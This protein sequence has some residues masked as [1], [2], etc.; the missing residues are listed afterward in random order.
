MAQASNYFILVAVDAET[1]EGKRVPAHALLDYRL[2]LKSWPLFQKTRNRF[3]MQPGDRLLFY[4]GGRQLNSRC[5]VARATIKSIQPVSG[6]PTPE[7]MLFIVD[8]PAQMVELQ[9]V[10]MFER[11]LDFRSILPLLDCAPANQT[12][13]GV[14]L[15]GGVRRISGKDYSA[16][17][18]YGE[19]LRG[20]RVFS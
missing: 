18:K 11:A 10:T 3:L 19:E 12:K 9:D 20:A 1:P 17:I 5:L 16:I 13:W 14:L 15:H 4:C 2:G 7:E 6:T 8:H